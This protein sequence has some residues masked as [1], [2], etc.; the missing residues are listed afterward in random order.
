MEIKATAR[1]T[2]ELDRMYKTVQVF[3]HEV[4]DTVA[5]NAFDPAGICEADE[6][7]V[8][9]VEKGIDQNQYVTAGSKGMRHLRNR[10]P[11]YRDPLP[12]WHDHVQFLVCEILRDV[13]ETIAEYGD[14]TVLLCRHRILRRA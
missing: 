5:A 6:V 12:A 8:T 10:Q 3:V 2:D 9:G 14:G 7:H 13:A 4:Q 11:T 1:L